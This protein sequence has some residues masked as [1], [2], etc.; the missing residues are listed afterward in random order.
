MGFFVDGKREGIFFTKNGEKAKFVEFE[1]DVL[2][3]E[4]KRGETIE[5]FSNS[6]GI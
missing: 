1:K 4:Q 3:N 2:V 5:S 6:L